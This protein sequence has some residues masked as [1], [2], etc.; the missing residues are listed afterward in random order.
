MIRAHDPASLW[1]DAREQTIHDALEVSASGVKPR[2]GGWDFSLRNGSDLPGAARLADSW[3]QL[4]LRP[5]G[6]RRK[7]TS[8]GLPWRMLETNATLPGNGKLVVDARTHRLYAAADVVLPEEAGHGDVPARVGD[9]CRGLKLAVAWLACETDD[10]A[11]APPA[12]KNDEL[13]ARLAERCREAG[14]PGKEQARG[15][16]RIDLGE[17]AP[18]I[19][20]ARDGGVH[21]SV[22][23]A[24]T[25]DVPRASQR[26]LA[27]FL[28]GLGAALRLVRP[29]VADGEVVLEAG[30]ESL[31]SPA[32]LARAFQACCVGVRTGA[33]EVRALLDADLAE[34]YLAL[35]GGA[36]CNATRETEDE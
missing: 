24:Q 31:P 3:L 17:R 4:S 2:A 6:V 9:A 18:A 7:L 32:E 10:V 15:G 5:A 19:V 35:H 33:A 12:K 16:L 1:P 21:V 13:G 14:W 22:G 23:L 34:T 27:L 36:I 8:P 29:A 20:S 30:F 26:P 25:D 28:I 11:E